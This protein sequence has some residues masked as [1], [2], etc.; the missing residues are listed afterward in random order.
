MDG[1]FAE[2]RARL[3]QTTG[4]IDEILGLLNNPDRPRRQVVD[5][6]PTFLK[7]TPT[8]GGLVR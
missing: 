7:R 5:P 8:S 2:M 3:D 4:G 6:L 1:G